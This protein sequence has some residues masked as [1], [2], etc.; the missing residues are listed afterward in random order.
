[1]LLQ[2]LI[3]VELLLNLRVER[4]DGECTIKFSPSE[5]SSDM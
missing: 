2:R 4:Q 5:S 1:M 3:G